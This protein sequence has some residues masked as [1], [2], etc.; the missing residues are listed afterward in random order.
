MKITSATLYSG[1][2]V[3][4]SF[5]L[6]IG[7]GSNRYL[8]RSIVG[9]DA[10][11]IVPRFYAHGQTSGTPFY[12][13]GMKARDIV[14]LVE[15]NPSFELGEDHGEVRDRMYRAISANRNGVIRLELMSGATTVAQISGFIVKFEAS[16]FTKSPQVQITLRCTDPLFR[17]VNPVQLTEADIGTGPTFVVPDSL[18]TAPHGFSMVLEITSD[19]DSITMLDQGVGFDT[20]F[21]I[22]PPSDFLDG[23]L[24]YFSSDRSNKY[25]YRDRSSVILQMMDLINPISVWPTLFPG[26]NNLHIVEAAFLTV[27]SLEYY[28]AYWGV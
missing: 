14:M 23:D 22:T 1:E 8:V 20:A 21:T 13:F 25:L 12:D 15:I 19:I 11:E 28:P 4:M 27:N 2:D 7:E 6:G 26:A 9:L 17:A 16:H 10:D 24:I 18:S 3:M 5:G